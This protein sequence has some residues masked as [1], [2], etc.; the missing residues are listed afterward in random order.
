[1]T[2]RWSGAPAASNSVRIQIFNGMVAIKDQLLARP[3]QDGDQS[4][5][6]DN[7]PPG[8]LIVAAKAF[9]QTDGSGTAQEQS[10]FGLTIQTGQT[11]DVTLALSGAVDRLQPAFTDYTV[12]IGGTSPLAVAAK[13]ASGAILLTAPTQSGWVSSDTGV[14]TVDAN[15]QASGVQLGTTTITL[16]DTVSN[17]SA[18][19][20]ITVRPRVNIAPASF[21]LTL[22]AARAL[23]AT[24]TGAS[25]QEVTWSV[26]EGGGGAITAAGYYTAPGNP[27]TYQVIATSQADPE[28][29]GTAIITVVAGAAS[30][31]VR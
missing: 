4:V 10:R 27:G 8:G 19:L 9:P 25:N 22:G 20:P 2:L 18:S 21:T 14:V 29:K 24:V 5:S 23:T 1:M 11:T 16:T 26:K 28:S 30:G 12:P 15:G 17:K 13:D 31:T 6:F 7:L 3:A